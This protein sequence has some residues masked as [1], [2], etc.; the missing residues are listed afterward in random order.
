MNLKLFLLICIIIVSCNTYSLISGTNNENSSL[1]YFIGPEIAVTGA[2]GFYDFQS[3]GDCRHQ[4][5]RFSP[6]VL[7]A[8]YMVSTD[9]LNINSSIRT[10]YCFSDNDGES[11]S[12]IAYAPVI[13]AVMPS[14]TCLFDGSAVITERVGNPVNTS[15]LLYDIAPGA[16]SFNNL[17]TPSMIY[18][19][20]CVVLSNGKVLVTGSTMTQSGITDSAVVT[21][22]DNSV[23][24]FSPPFKFKAANW[25][26]QSNMRMTYAACPVGKAL[27]VL[28][29]VNDQGGNNGRNRLFITFTSDFGQSWTPPVVLYNPTVLNGELTVPFLGLDAVYD[30]FSNY[31]IAFNTTDSAGNYSSAKLW[32]VKNGGNPVLVCSHNNIPEAAS[33]FQTPQTGVCSVDNPSISVSGNGAQLFVSYSVTFQNDTLNG[34]NKSHIY[35]SV[36]GTG[37]LQFSSP[38]KITNS[39]ISSFDERYSSINKISPD[40][41]GSYGYTVFLV[42]QKDVQ[43]GSKIADNAA[44]S[45]SSLMF[46]KISGLNSFPGVIYNNSNIPLVTILKQN[47]PNP[48]NPVTQIKFD[49]SLTSDINLS[50]YDLNGKKITDIYSN[51]SA[52]PGEYKIDFNG[53]N[54][55]SGVYFLTLVVGGNKSDVK[56]FTRKILLLK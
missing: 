37:S 14:L 16:G 21:I 50:L 15:Q 42:Y 38:I 9:S 17:S 48:F 5:Y 36:S 26:D 19:S 3:I 32:V 35:L 8:V 13:S 41:G 23:N 10:V 54:F 46:R 45:R 1:S 11:W 6:A 27:I 25:V 43:P 20:G 55:A 52:Q 47:Y 12:F 56:V 51:F 28:S 18:N 30:N 33:V 22:F 44:A 40:L 34:F 29:P 53:T 24:S 49:I 2:N 31:Y 4:I 7:H 39:G